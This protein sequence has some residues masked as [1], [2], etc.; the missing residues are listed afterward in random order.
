MWGIV[1]CYC[2]WMH[3][4]VMHCIAAWRFLNWTKHTVISHLQKPR[5]SYMG[6]MGSWVYSE[7][8]FANMFFFC[9][10]QECFANR[11]TSPLPVNYGSIGLTIYTFC[12]WK[13]GIFVVPN[14]LWH[15]ASFSHIF[16]TSKGHWEPFLNCLSFKSSSNYEISWWNFD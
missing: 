11:E 8:L 3:C 13:G 12:L 7:R 9:E 10:V 5:W 15:G 1:P 4:C 14:H 16:T 6:Y 2:F